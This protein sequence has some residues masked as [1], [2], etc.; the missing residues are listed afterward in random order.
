MA[1]NQ[2]TRKT[3]QLSIKQ[4]IEVI[5]YLSVLLS[6][7]VKV[8]WIIIFETHDTF[9]EAR[10]GFFRIFSRASMVAVEVLAI[11]S[12]CFFMYQLTKP[13]TPVSRILTITGLVLQS[14]CLGMEVFQYL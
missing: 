9:Q 2:V 10:A 6:I 5:A 11:G 8:A 12:F 1:P 4:I 13:Q 14:L 7:Y 3:Y